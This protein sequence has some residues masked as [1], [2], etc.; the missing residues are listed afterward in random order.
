MNGNKLMVY[1]LVTCNLLNIVI[2]PPTKYKNI[3]KKDIFNK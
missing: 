2:E 1:A 3:N